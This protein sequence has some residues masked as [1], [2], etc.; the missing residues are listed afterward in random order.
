[1][2]DQFAMSNARQI[3]PVEP[4]WLLE[5]VGLARI[6]TTQPIEGP[7]P[8]GNMRLQLRSHQPSTLGDLTKVTVVDAWDG[9]VLEQHLYDPAGQRLATAITSSYKRDPIS[10][11]ALPKSI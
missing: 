11:A 2:H 10:G 1:R 4:E 3:M 6:D 9:T 5:A 8:V 7:T